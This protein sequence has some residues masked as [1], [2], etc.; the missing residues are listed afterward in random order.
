MRK[1]DRT[2][3][4]IFTWKTLVGKNHGRQSA[5]FAMM[6]ELQRS[7]YNEPSLFRAAYKMY[8]YGGLN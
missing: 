1:Q 2:R 7:E 6:R 5:I 8:I 4:T 3:D